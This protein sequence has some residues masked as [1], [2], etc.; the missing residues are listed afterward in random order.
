[1]KL[2]LK[3]KEELIRQIREQESKPVVR[4]SGYDPSEACGHGLLAEMSVLELRERL[5]LNKRKLL[6]ELELKR[7]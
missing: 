3:R 1:M 5:E 6:Q 7:D 2:E 4:N